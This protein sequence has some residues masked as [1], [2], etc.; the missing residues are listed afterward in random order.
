MKKII[1]AGANGFIGRHL[2]DYFLGLDYEVVCLVRG[3]G[4]APDGT[5]E[6]Q[7]DGRTLGDW[8]DEFENGSVVVNLAGR[9]VNCRYHER[10]R[11]EI[12]VS[13][14]ETTRVLG[15]AIARTKTPPI[16]WINSSTA[17]IYRHAE[18][19]PQD[20]YQ[21]EFG[22]GFSV[23]VAKAWEKAFFGAAV[24]GTVRKVALRTA[25]VLANEPGTVFDYFW[26]IARMGLGGRMGSGRQRISWVH[27]ED[28][29]RA[30]RWI[31]EH[32]EF[33][34][35]ANVVAPE[36][37]TN[38]EFMDVMREMVRA[39]FGLPAAK[40]MIGLGTWAMRTEAELV[41]K[42]RWIHAARLQRDG[43]EFRWRT[44]RACLEDLT[45]E[46]RVASVP[47]EAEKVAGL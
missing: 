5:K 44:L 23:A 8:A 3:L 29:C 39:P 11:A 24:P 42:S 35:V 15:K 13:R 6:V 12:L 43:F 27:I 18:D 41:L 9:S 30:V 1:I 40:W 36:V 2:A 21:G 31:I 34:G 28:F 47:G 4:S 10:N 45:P 25:L 22:D 33:D 26:K 7:W 37:P 38:R 20:E 19:R 46:G 17:T 16:L 14:T 32:E